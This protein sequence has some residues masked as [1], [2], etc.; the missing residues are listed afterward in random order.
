MIEIINEIMGNYLMGYLTERQMNCR[1]QHLQLYM[2][3]S[4][5]LTCHINL[6]GWVTS[7][8]VACHGSDCNQQHVEAIKN[9]VAH[10]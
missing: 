8:L 4:S 2:F 7:I 5:Q 10:V 1:N 3:S 6:S 9:I